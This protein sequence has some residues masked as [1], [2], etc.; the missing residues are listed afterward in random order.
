MKDVLIY[1][2]LKVTLIIMNSIL[3]MR[4]FSLCGRLS[5]RYQSSVHDAGVIIFIKYSNT[6]ATNYYVY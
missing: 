2:I 4:L 3:R 1:L 6:A 5:S